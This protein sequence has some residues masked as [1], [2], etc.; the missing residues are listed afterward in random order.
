MVY[1]LDHHECRERLYAI[2]SRF[3]KIVEDP[4]HP[5]F[6]TEFFA[7]PVALHSDLTS[8]FA[9]TGGGHDPEYVRRSRKTSTWIVLF[10]LS[11]DSKAISCQAISRPGHWRRHCVLLAL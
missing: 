7:P 10:L 11:N 8:S 2:T 1:H 5:L 9:G 4:D 3:E 6:E